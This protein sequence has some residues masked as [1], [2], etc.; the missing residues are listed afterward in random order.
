MFVDFYRHFFTHVEENKELLAQGLSLQT[1]AHAA[2]PYAS[3]GMTT[4][5]HAD[6]WNLVRQ[7]T[8]K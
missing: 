3:F 5:E 7:G 1:I 4:E 8:T 6:F 2:M